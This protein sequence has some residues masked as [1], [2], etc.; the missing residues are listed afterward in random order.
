MRQDQLEK[1]FGVQRK[2][3]ALYVE[4]IDTA[5]EQYVANRNT[6]DLEN[7]LTCFILLL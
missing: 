3:I 7:L 4:E 6:K 1:K 2:Q 5:L